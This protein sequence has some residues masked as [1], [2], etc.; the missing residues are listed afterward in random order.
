MT[1]TLTSDIDI[2]YS[3]SNKLMQASTPAELLEAVGDYAREQGATHGNLF[4]T[5]E[6][7]NPVPEQ[8]E[9]VAGWTTG[10]RTLAKPG[11]RLSISSIEIEKARHT[12]TGFCEL[13]ED[14]RLSQTPLL[15]EIH[16]ETLISQGICSLAILALN[17]R[18][19]WVGVVQF[20]WDQPYQFTDRDR[21]IFAGLTQQTAPIVDSIRLLATNRQRAERREIL[22]KINEALSKAADETQ[23]LLALAP[24]FQSTQ[25][26]RIMLG[27]LDDLT[28][29]PCPVAFWSNGIAELYDPAK[30]HVVNLTKKYNYV[31]LWHPYPEQV[32]FI[33]NLAEDPRFDEDT[34]K[35]IMEDI[36]SRAMTTFPFFSGG[37]C[38]GVLSVGWLEPHVFSEEEKFIYSSLLPTL[39]ATVASR[40]AY[41]AEQEAR[42]ESELLYR[43]GEAINAAN[44]FQEIVNAVTKLNFSSGDFYLNIFENFDYDNAR[45]FDIVATSTDFFKHQGARWW[46]REFSLA[47]KYPRQGLYINE[48]IAENT[49]IDADS[50]RH[51]LELGVQSNM[52]VS[53]SLNGRFMGGL[54]VDD[55][56]PRRFSA[57]ERRLMEGIGDLVSAAVERIRL[58]ME[59][60]A[61]RQRAETLAHLNGALLQATDETSILKALAPYA[62]AQGAM[63]LSLLYPEKDSGEKLVDFRIIALWVDGEVVASAQIQQFVQPYI[64]E[65][66]LY[67]L[68]TR[69]PERVLFIEDLHLDS[70]FSETLRREWMLK[71]RTRAL[72][73]HPLYS[74]GKWQG[75]LHL[76]WDEPHPFSSEERF[77][78]SQL[79][80]TL[81]SVV[82]TRRAYLA[83]QEALRQTE[84]AHQRAVSLAQIN[85]ALLQATDEA[86][87]LSALAPFA[88]SHGAASLVLTYA[89]DIE[90]ITP[91]SF[92]PKALWLLGAPVPFQ[93]IDL[94]LP[95]HDLVYAIRELSLRE[96]GKPLFIENVAMDA[97]IDEALRTKFIAQ[98]PT[99]RTRAEVVLGLFSGGRWQGSLVVIWFDEPH[100][101]TEQEKYIYTQLLQTLPSVVATRRAYLAEQ[102]ARQETDASRQQAETLA[103]V[104]AALSQAADEREILSA[105]ARLAEDYGADLS[106]L[107]YIVSVEGNPLDRVNIVALRTGDTKQPVP[108]NTLPIISFRV[109]DYPLLRLV[110]ANPNEPVFLEDVFS[111]PRTEEGNTREFARRV[112]WG[113]AVLIPLKTTDHWQGTLSF[114]WKQKRHFPIEIRRLFAAIQP[115]VTSV[116]AHRRAYLAE[117]QRAH[118]LETVA[119]VSAAATSI[120][121]ESELLDAIAELTRISFRQYHFLI[122]LLDD[123][124]EF[125]VQTLSSAEQ[126]SERLSIPISSERSLVAR[127]AQTR[128]GIIVND[129]SNTSEYTLAPM[130]R[131]ARSEMAVP[132][133]TGDRLIGVLD[134]Q[135]RE[136][137]RFTESD[138]WVMQTL[139]DLIAVAIQNARLYQQAQELA[140][141]EERNR[142]AR[143]LHD[144]VSQ[145]LYGIA[146]GA[147]TAR[148]LLERDPS[149]LSEPLDYVLSLAEAGLT[150][151]RALIFDLRP[152]SLEEEGLIAALGKQIASIKARHGIQMSVEVCE[153]PQLPLEIKEGL[154]W[155]AREALHN[156]V[157]HAQ[158]SHVV[159]HMSCDAHEILLEIQDNG[160]G[161]D[162]SGAFP[163]HLGLHSMRDRATRLNGLLEI[164]SSPGQGTRIRVHVPRVTK[165]VS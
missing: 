145:A 102:E 30:H 161:F 135:S 13:I 39:S 120:L 87:I 119:K 123:Q 33:E 15:K 80:Q 51:F 54:G 74:A 163:G 25:A 9:I 57:Q 3:A 134:V 14:V 16:R 157:K 86:S 61:S 32:L 133:I 59:T 114:V 50:R 156:T 139:A 132:I 138:I 73:L 85:G 55:A 101:F 26:S 41:L 29:G 118:Q 125:L 44:T 107:A 53:L 122:Y 153:E 11:T 113:A 60:D 62:Q 144:S 58:R 152:D 66:E 158:A 109:D 143:E 63:G 111:D 45:Y 129:I 93:D 19:R 40:R 84:V 18:G 23:I 36:P 127:A 78:Y 31:K 10:S 92:K 82:A 89:D 35:N 21:R 68:A 6:N 77:I 147:R 88:E 43:A 42:H 1:T 104:N 28:E 34:R 8:I 126:S 112:E 159:L 115:V 148:T 22:L 108:L 64:I 150:E 96:P 128:Q 106:V 141:F 164:D 37:K 81:P 146:L 7:G 79:L 12:Y 69:D 56:K 140:A 4:Y 97:R 38:I 121:K 110:E 75:V 17:N 160:L 149:R 165:T 151:M 49:E 52:R 155:I 27:Y 136:I 98:H 67:A 116:V 94:N 105:V 99:Y 76:M 83:E 71:R 100:L 103:Q 48:N 65:H 90:A 130:V 142:L 20:C 5:I 91:A 24:Y 95:M 70:R 2:L 137:N 72:A 46:L 131:N 124:P 162:A 47:K 154:Y 117:Q